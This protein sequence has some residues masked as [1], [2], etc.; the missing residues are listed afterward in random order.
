MNNGTH[1][2]NDEVD[3]NED[4]EDDHDDV[5]GE[6]NEWIMIAATSLTVKL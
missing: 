6:R 4:D 3:V 2:K 5:D 1:D